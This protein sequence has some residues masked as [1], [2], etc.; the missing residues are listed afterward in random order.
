MLHELIQFDQPIKSVSHGGKHCSAVEQGTQRSSN[1]T[2]MKADA[3]V[4]MRV[5]VSQRTSTAQHSET[6]H[7]VLM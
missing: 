5:A 1:G 6:Q 3:N 7:S 4:Q 2:R